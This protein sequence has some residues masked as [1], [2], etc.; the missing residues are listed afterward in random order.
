M[1]GV[2]AEQGCNV[3]AATQHTKNHHVLVFDAIEDDVLADGKAPQAG[4]QIFVA[5]TPQIR[6]SGEKKE[7]V[8]DGAY[9]TVSISVLPL[10]E[11]T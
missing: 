7:P 5:G 8:R 3:P 11:A 9:E 6:I 4:A 2:R 10:W 1:L